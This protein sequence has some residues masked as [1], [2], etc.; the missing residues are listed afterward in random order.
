MT[1]LIVGSWIVH[2]TPISCLP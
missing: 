2:L 1:M